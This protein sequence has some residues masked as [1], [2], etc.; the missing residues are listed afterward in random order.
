MK[1][2]QPDECALIRLVRCCEPKKKV[3]GVSLIWILSTSFELHSDSDSGF[4]SDSDSESSILANM[5]ML[6]RDGKESRRK[7]DEP[8]VRDA[9]MDSSNDG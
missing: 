5:S 8:G 4:D 6:D 9:R 7:D 1:W 3:D 2:I